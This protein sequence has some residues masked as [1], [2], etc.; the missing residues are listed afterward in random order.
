MEKLEKFD[1]LSIAILT[2]EIDKA[3]EEIRIKYG[4][5]EL[6]VDLVKSNNIT[7]TAKLTGRVSGVHAKNFEHNMALLFADYNGLPADL[8]NQE[9][10]SNGK[11]FTVIRIEPRNPRYPI[12]ARGLLDNL[13]YKFSV[14]QVKEALE[15]KKR[16]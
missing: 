16:V 6:V 9:F 15:R 11:G 8:L 3:L 5:E 13:V 14:I 1:R 4:L 2:E 12:L 10:I 7:M